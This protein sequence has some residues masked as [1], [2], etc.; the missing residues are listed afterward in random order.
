MQATSV[1]QRRGE[2]RLTALV[3]VQDWKLATKVVGLCVGVSL[4]RAAGLTALGYAQASA[5]LKE[6]AEAALG[7]D[8]QLV[9]DGVDAWNAERLKGVQAIATL[10]RVRRVLEA[11]PNATSDETAAAE[12]DLASFGAGFT[13]LTT[14]SIQDPTGTLIMSTNPKSRGG[15]LK[16]RDYFQSAMQGRSFISGVSVALADDQRVIFRS[17][18]VKGG[19]GKVIGAAQART[20]PGHVQ[21]LVQAAKDRVGTGATGIL[22]D[23]QGL[24]I[25]SSV[26][27]SWLLRPVVPL[28]AQVSDALI[29]DKRWGNHPMPEP[30]GENDLAPVIGIHERTFFTWRTGGIEY[31]AL[32]VPLQQTHWTYVAALPVTTFQRSAD[33]FLRAATLA[34]VLGLLLASVVAVLFARPIAGAMKQM[35]RAAKG[36]ALGDLDQQIDARSRDEVGEMAQAFQAMIGYQ[37]EMARVA[38][39]VAKGDLTHDVQPKTHRDVLG[40]AFQRMNGSLRELVG[41][42]QTAAV[43]LADASSALGSNS[44]QTGIAASQ[45]AA[46]VQSVADGFQTTRQNAQTTTE[47]MAQL[48]Q[49]IDGIARGAADQASQVQQASGTA[50][51]MATGVEQVAQNADQV[52]AASEQSKEAA[53]HCAQAVQE[54]VEGMAEIREVVTQVAAKVEDLGNLGEKIGAVVNTIDDIAEQTNLLALNAAI[55]AARAGKHGEGFAVVADEVRKLAERSGRE[56]RQIA[57]L[58]QQVQ[59]GT[60]EAV[61]AMEQGS[62]K[63]EAGSEKAEQAGQ[64]LQEI[65]HAIENTVEQVGGI[66]GAAQEMAIGVRSVTDAMQSISAVVEENSA[67]TEEMS[68]QAGQVQTAVEGIAHVSESQS[69][70]IE[71]IS[72]GAEE[73]NGQIEEMGA[74]IQELA[75]MAEQLKGPVARF[76]VEADAASAPPNVV[77]LKR[78]A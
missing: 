29:Q 55:E 63:V 20:G 47:A 43:Q 13:D 58:I 71:E 25:G 27:A 74:Q 39:A 40:T 8:A 50:T 5:G 66:A 64:A 48:N 34:A 2:H 72:A 51:Q 3:R 24:V 17:A 41:Q 38:E 49:A 42:V 26:D 75:A 10:P 6:Q 59:Q 33:S 22:V 73:M 46:G 18:P 78:A 44:G 60:R 61:K 45:V 11:G 12:A 4:V 70:A 35:T 67:A 14:I 32:A 69:A 19:D 53:A 28:S 57:E 1:E 7:S 54:T 16:Q 37:R 68:A 76:K 56:T 30:L 36:L 77:S 52:A 23:E 9:A 62:G 31:R 21:E 65:L 15:N